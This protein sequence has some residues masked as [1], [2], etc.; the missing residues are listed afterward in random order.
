MDRIL[1]IAVIVALLVTVPIAIKFSGEAKRLQKDLTTRTEAVSAAQTE[2]THVSDSLKYMTG[3]SVVLSSR[4]DSISH[5]YDRALTDGLQ[6]TV[7]IARLSRIVDSL[8]ALSNDRLAQFQE[9]GNILASLK[10]RLADSVNTLKDA[11]MHL[12]S[13]RAFVN[14]RNVFISQIQPWYI[15][16]KHDAT[17]RNWFEKLF[18]AD[19]AKTPSIPE[20]E[21][22]TAA[23]DSLVPDSTPKLQVLR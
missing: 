13:T 3:Q 21:F 5:R 8:K 2:L 16:W 1:L 11:R 10:I 7:K 4:L 12:D 6:L 9:Q 19:K 14:E 17:E 15:K 20:P 23:I 22:P 18:G